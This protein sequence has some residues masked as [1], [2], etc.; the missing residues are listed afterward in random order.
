MAY[1]VIKEF[2]DIPDGWHLYKVGDK[3][4]RD[5]VKVSDERI[6]LFASDRNNTGA[7]LIEKVSVKSTEK[8]KK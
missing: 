7:V 1:R 2:R 8:K 5:G 4:P 3:Y 6:A